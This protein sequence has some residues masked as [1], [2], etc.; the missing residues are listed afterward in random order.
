[1][2]WPPRTRELKCAEL[3]YTFLGNQ[4]GYCPMTWRTPHCS[5]LTN[6]TMDITYP[7]VEKEYLL[8]TDLSLTED[9]EEVADEVEL[10]EPD[11]T[12]PELGDLD[13]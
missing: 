8:T 9:E 7:E 12:G 6:H 2:W 3:K 1:M 5:Q 10:E 11:F 4:L 13:R